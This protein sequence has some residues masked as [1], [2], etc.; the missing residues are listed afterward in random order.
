MNTVETVLAAV[1]AAVAVKLG[2]VLLGVLWSMIR[3]SKVKSFGDWAVVTGATDGIGL[4]YCHEFAR[5]GLNVVLISRT[6]SK[7]D[8]CAKDISKRFPKVQVKTIQADFDTDCYMD[9]Q[10]ALAGVPV[11]ILVNNVGRSYNHAEYLNLISDE[12]VDSLIRLNVVS[13]TKM[14]RMV[15]QGMLERKKGAIVNVSSAAGVIHT[16]DPF[17]AV[18]SATKAYV[19]FFSRSLHLELASK[20]VS[21]QCQVPYFVTTKLAKIRRSSLTVPSPKGYAQ[22]AV[23][24]IGYGATVVPF[25]MHA[26]QHWFIENVV[27]SFLFSYFLVGHHVS[28]RNRAYK[29]MA[30]AKSN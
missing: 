22:A 12:L 7:L 6:Q 3:P 24:C 23:Q 19:D 17:Y 4:A 27:P 20:G 15:L 29:K 30:G 18:Y 13:T 8:D 16:G 14:T 10:K 1:G 5:N 25:P 9:I 11:G 26:L 28:I 21:V 2:L